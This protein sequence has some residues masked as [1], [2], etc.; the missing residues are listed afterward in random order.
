MERNTL[1]KGI[2]SIAV[3]VEV[4]AVTSGA[5]AAKRY[6][7][8]SSSQIKAGAVSLSDLSPAARKALRGV[9]GNTATAAPQGPQGPQGAQGAKGAQ[10]PAG[11]D[12]QGRADPAEGAAGRTGPG[13]APVDRRL[14]RD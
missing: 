10:G 11:K 2:T 7:I 1:K 12:G 8:T 9:N 4:L 14:R 13:D 5:F 3:L 6:L